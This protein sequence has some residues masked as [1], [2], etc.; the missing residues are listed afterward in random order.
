M[1][2]FWDDED[3]V[4][5]EDYAP[6]PQE[7]AEDEWQSVGK[8]PQPTKKKKKKKKGKKGKNKGAKSGGPQGYFG[9]LAGDGSASDDDADAA[10]QAQ[11]QGGGLSVS[12]LSAPRRSQG[13]GD[14]SPWVVDLT[15]G[16]GQVVEIGLDFLKDFKTAKCAREEP[17]LKYGEK[18]QALRKYKEARKLEKKNRRKQE[19]QAAKEAPSSAEAAAAAEVAAAAAA[20]AAAVEK[21][22][23]APLVGLSGPQEGD[24]EVL[25]GISFTPPAQ[26]DDGSRANTMTW[27]RQLPDG[28]VQT[29]TTSCDDATAKDWRSTVA[30]LKQTSPQGRPGLPAKRTASYAIQV[31]WADG[32]TC[33]ETDQYNAP[34]AFTPFGSI[35]S[36]VF[37]PGKPHG[38]IDFQDDSISFVGRVCSQMHGREVC[39]RK[40]LLEPVQNTDNKWQRHRQRPQQPPP[41][42]QQQQ[43]TM[44]PRE[45]GQ[46]QPPPLQ[47]SEE[48]SPMPEKTEEQVAAAM[49]HQQKM[50]GAAGAAAEEGNG[51]EPAEDSEAF[52]QAYAVR[53]PCLLS[54]CVHARR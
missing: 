23:L 3:G 49:A 44:T 48:K 21:P 19:K 22:S 32:G 28:R 14:G 43:P 53:L 31:R 36:A 46:R 30:N 37:R 52:W 5:M 15:L 12:Q 38:W 41:Q 13:D 42:Q 24:L 7:P 1:G 4:D 17:V 10:A 8:A 50:R 16:S 39:G 45:P 40:V 27:R 26:S 33:T 6:E 11:A 29:I 2:A 25:P 47:R 9:E 18:D 35:K 51:D 54:I 20:P 34:A